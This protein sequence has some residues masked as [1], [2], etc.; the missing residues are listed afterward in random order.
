M[1]QEVKAIFVLQT[2]PRINQGRE[3]IYGA[4]ASYY[5]KTHRVSKIKNN[6]STNW[7]ELEKKVIQNLMYYV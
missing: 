3:I 2:F 6:N 7:L 5:S 1:H 4:I